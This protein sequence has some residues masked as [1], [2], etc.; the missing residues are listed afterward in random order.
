MAPEVDANEISMVTVL[1]LQLF[2]FLG[3]LVIL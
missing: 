1:T 3:G 2:F